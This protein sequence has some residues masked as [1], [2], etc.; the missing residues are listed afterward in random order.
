[1]DLRDHNG[2]NDQPCTNNNNH[3]NARGQPKEEST[4]SNKNSHSSN[5]VKNFRSSFGQKTNTTPGSTA[6][7]KGPGAQSNKSGTATNPTK[8]NGNSQGSSLSKE[9]RDELKAANKCFLCSQEGHFARNCPTKSKARSNNGKP[10]GM[11][12]FG[13]RMKYTDRAQQK[14]DELGETTEMSI[15]MIG[16]S[17]PTSDTS[18]QTP[19]PKEKDCDGDT[20]PDLQ[21]VTDSDIDSTSMSDNI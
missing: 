14:I 15:G 12:A 9:E 21:L 19:W 16:W 20:I 10:P 13:I 1:M 17:R 8:H 4:K 3:S 18:L 7:N 11:S 2:G 6:T 5:R